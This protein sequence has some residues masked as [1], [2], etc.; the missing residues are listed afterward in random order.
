MERNSAIL[1]ALESRGDLKAG[2]FVCGH[3]VE[4]PMGGRILKSWN[5]RGHEI[6]NHS[7]SHWNYN[8][9]SMTFAEFAAD[10]D[11]C[12]E[13]ISEYLNFR[14]L[15]RYPFLKEGETLEKR[16]QMRDHLE[17]RGYGIGAVTIDNSDWYADQRLCE[18]LEAEPTA[19]MAPYREYYLNHMLERIHYYDDLMRTALGRSPKHTLLTHHNL[20]NA[21]FLG[22]LLGHLQ[23]NGI[24][25]IDVDEAYSDP[26][27]ER[28]PDVVPAGESLAWAL[29][30][31][32]GR[33]LRYPSESYIYEKEILDG[34]GL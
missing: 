17:A 5:K 32:G 31:E 3:K 18:R 13:M 25:L 29:T 34:L 27:Y 28:W 24:V 30:Y 33:Q 14:P 22:D 7:Y 6:C 23:D 2:L 8:D 20:L 9:G 19:D 10:F 26:V 21:L 16:D 1:G 11:R 4:T 15:F 12:D